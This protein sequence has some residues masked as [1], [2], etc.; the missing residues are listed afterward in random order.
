M[1]AP[2]PDPTLS[3]V[4]ADLVGR[5]EQDKRLRAVE[6]QVAALQGLPGAIERMEDRIT[7]AIAEGRP[8]PVWP[9][10]SSIVAAVALLLVVAQ[11]LYS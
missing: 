7:R 6:Q 2:M 10:V 1:G 4:H 11:A 8:R 9:A 5:L 3:E